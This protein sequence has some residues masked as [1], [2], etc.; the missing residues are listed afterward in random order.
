[1][2]FDVSSVVFQNVFSEPRSV[3]KISPHCKSVALKLHEHLHVKHQTHQR[4]DAEGGH[5]SSLPFISCPED[6]M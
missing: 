3:Q 4:R 2:L 6:Q 5:A 1:M